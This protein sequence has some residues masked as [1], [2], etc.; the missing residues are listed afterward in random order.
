LQADN[1]TDQTQTQ[2]AVGNPRQ[3]LDWQRYGTQFLFGVTYKV[4]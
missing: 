3:V 1:L 2:Y 4:N